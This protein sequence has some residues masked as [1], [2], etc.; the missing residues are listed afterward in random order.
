[1]KHLAAA[2]LAAGLLVAACGESKD[3]TADVVDK[4][5]VGA[6]LRVLFE[7]HFERGLEMDPLGATFIGDY[8]YNDRLANYNGPEYIAAAMAI[9]GQALAYKIG[10][11]KIR[12]IRDKAA[13][14]LGDNFSVRAFHTEVLK[15]GAMP[16]S[17]LE[18]K[19]DRWVSA[20]L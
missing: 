6:T 9:P 7:E 11:L 19:L 3:H 10:Q 5:D 16:L 20:Q 12:K 15:D 1:M 14:P 17:M 18:A 8:R 13:A 2:I 4:I